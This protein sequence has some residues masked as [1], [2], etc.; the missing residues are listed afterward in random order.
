VECEKCK[1]IEEELLNIKCYYDALCRS[2]DN[3]EVI[4]E[5]TNLLKILKKL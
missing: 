1:K 3:E 5:I 2:V 4:E